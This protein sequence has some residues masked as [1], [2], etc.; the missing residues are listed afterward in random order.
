L[1]AATHEVAIVLKSV[2]F[3]RKPFPSQNLSP[4][5]YRDHA[6]CLNFRADE[7]V[8]SR[9]TKE[10][11]IGVGEFSDLQIEK[12]RL[13]ARQLCALEELRRDLAVELT[14]GPTAPQELRSAQ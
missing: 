3:A 5:R 1:D 10:S 12:C 6:I 13:V 11:G 4:I 14:D 9:V 2:A 7:L 8:F